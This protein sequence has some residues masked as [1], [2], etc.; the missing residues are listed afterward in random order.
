MDGPTKKDAIRLVIIQPYLPAYRAPVYKRL[1]AEPDIDLTVV[2]AS[3]PWIKNV[4]PIGFRAVFE[5]MKIVHI[6]RHPFYWQPSFTRWAEPSRCDA[7]IL[8][9]DAHYLHLLPSIL[10]ARRNG[11]GT[12]VWGHGYSKNRGLLAYP[13]RRLGATAD[14]LAFYTER[15]RR[16]LSEFG[17][18]MK[19]MFVAYNALDTEPI[20]AAILHWKSRP[21]DL[22]AFRVEQGIAPDEA[23]VLFV[24]RIGPERRIDM[25][26]EAASKLRDRR[27]RIVLV[28]GGDEPTAR[29]LEARAAELGIGDRLK[30]VGPCYDEKQLAKWFLSARV[31]C[32]PSSIG[33]SLMHAFAYSV[34]VIT[35]DLSDVHGPEFEALHAEQ[36]SLTY[37]NGDVH[38]LAAQLAR[39]LD[40]A[41]LAQRLGWAA[42]RTIDETYNI[43][44][45]VKGLADAARYA[46]SVQRS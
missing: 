36:N 14:A 43:G 1:A 31:Q 21:D 28:G 3:T 40:D 20:D 7:M 2:H 42:R 39:L 19:R 41:P 37:R 9:W 6:R 27:F 8:N 15:G 30:R 46:V 11:I 29:A 44:R 5:P 10:K 45:M 13:R 18:E 34:P 26:L 32:F 4:E 17:V 33:L 24:A 12:V 16:E 23:I 38:S 22:A 25:L 35:S